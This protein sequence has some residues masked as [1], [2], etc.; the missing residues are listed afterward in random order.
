MG[1][2]EK[3][4]RSGLLPYID[5]HH[6]T[7]RFFV[8]LGGARVVIQRYSTSNLPPQALSV[9]GG[10]FMTRT[11]HPLAPTSLLTHSHT[12]T[13][14][15]NRHDITDMMM[16]VTLGSKAFL[17]LNRSHATIMQLSSHPF[18]SKHVHN[19]HRPRSKEVDQQLSRPSCPD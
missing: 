1:V 19:T 8:R 17:T 14:M 11:R 9:D 15:C 18:S 10:V 2:T 3:T 7:I 5:S 4:K 13:H 16:V 6:H 12:H